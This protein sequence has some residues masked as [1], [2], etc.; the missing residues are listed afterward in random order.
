MSVD[1]ILWFTAAIKPS[2]F[3]LLLLLFTDILRNHLSTRIAFIE[4]SNFSATKSLKQ[5]FQNT[6]HTFVYIK[7]PLQSISKR[8]MHAIQH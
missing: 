5:E 7:Q 2:F 3:L 1:I 8:Q 4:N 6:F